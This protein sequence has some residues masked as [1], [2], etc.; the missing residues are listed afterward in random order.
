VDIE[1]I[2]FHYETPL[3]SPQYYCAACM[4]ILGLERKETWCRVPQ[5]I[6]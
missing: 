2:H 6:T 4:P 3:P 1:L 5:E